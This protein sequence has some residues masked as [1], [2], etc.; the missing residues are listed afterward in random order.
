MKNETP[1]ISVIIPCYNYAHF[2]PE[3]IESVLNQKYSHL[4]CIVVNDGSTD[5][6][7]EVASR[8]MAKDSR[9]K[10][11]QQANQGLSAA[12]NTGIGAAEGSYILPLD[13]DDFISPDYAI[14]AVSVLEG[15]R[16]I[17]IVYCDAQFFGSSHTK[18]DLPPYSFPEILL[19]NRIFASAFFRKQDWATCGGYRTNMKLGWEDYDFWLSII[20]M[21]REVHKIPEVLFYY[22]QGHT[23]MRDITDKHQAQLYAQIAK[24]HPALY[25]DNIEFLF[26]TLLTAQEDNIDYKK[27]LREIKRSY[28]YRVF[29]K[30]LF[31]AEKLLKKLLAPS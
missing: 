23:S 10:Y 15:S 31:N 8:F 14:K 9:I 29:F 1:L 3:A 17:G 13:A 7:H 30:H 21:G 5:N 6:T 26:Q 22:R 11:V 16:N 2:L 24:N 18:F 19:A 28:T 12:R 27:T 4:E 20:E 25:M